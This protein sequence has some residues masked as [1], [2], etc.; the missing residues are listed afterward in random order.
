V[1]VTVGDI[2]THDTDSEPHVHATWGEWTPNDRSL[3]MLNIYRTAGPISSSHIGF[4]V[5][6]L[7]A[8]HARLAGA[9]VE[10]LQTSAIRVRE[11]LLNA[12]AGCNPASFLHSWD[13][14][15]AKD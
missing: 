4:A 14:W 7:P 13:R 3:Q 6:D 2:E 8:T 1:G 10:V 12:L 11:L 5:N 15:P 9:N